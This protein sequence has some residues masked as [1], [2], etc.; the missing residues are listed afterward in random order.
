MPPHARGAAMAPAGM[1]FCHAS[2]EMSKSTRA[3]SMHTVQRQVPCGPSATARRRR[4]GGMR[5]G[6]RQ[7]PAGHAIETA[8]RLRNRPR[9]NPDESRH[10][11]RRPAAPQ[12]GRPGA[13]AGA[14]H[15]GPGHGHRSHAAGGLQPPGQR[16]EMAGDGADLPRAPGHHGHH[17]AGLAADGRDRPARGLLSGRAVWRRFPASSPAWRSSHSVSPC[18][19]WPRSCRACRRGSSGISGSPP[20]TPPSRSSGPRRYRW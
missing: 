18:C 5:R 20:P 6:A 7:P 3:S 10:L 16:G 1:G 15:V 11:S 12:R 4:N 14:V 2:G 8:V 13:R 9:P 17:G 19:A